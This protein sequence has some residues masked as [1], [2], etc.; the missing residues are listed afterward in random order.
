MFGLCI[1]R[2]LEIMRGSLQQLAA[3]LLA[4]LLAS[5]FGLAPK[6]LEASDSTGLSIEPGYLWAGYAGSSFRSNVDIGRPIVGTG[7][8]GELAFGIALEGG[9]EVSL[10]WASVNWSYHDSSN[11]FSYAANGIPANGVA[12]HGRMEPILA[13]FRFHTS[14][15]ARG[16]GIY[17]GLLAGTAEVTGNV[18]RSVNSVQMAWAGDEWA[19]ALGVTTGFSCR[20]GSRVEVGIGSRSLY[21]SGTKL[22]PASPPNGS[23]GPRLRFHATEAACLITGFS[24][25]W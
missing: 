2:L 9:Y 12:G 21:V 3:R 14:L 20:L 19:P 10:E 18:Y 24:V 7:R 8:G 4:A 1:C 23:I 25:G 22:T 5:T 16:L 11:S 13:D 17:G 6:L 15:P